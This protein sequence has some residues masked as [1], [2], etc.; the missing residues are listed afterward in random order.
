VKATDGGI[1]EVDLGTIA[2]VKG[3]NARV[4]AFGDMMI[5][6]HSAANDQLK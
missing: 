1:M 2:K 6:D 3:Q 4:K 5:T